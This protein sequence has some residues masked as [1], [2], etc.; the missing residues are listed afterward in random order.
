MSK[1]IEERKLPTGITEFDALI[2]DLMSEYGD[3]MPTQDVES[4][5]FVV[6]TIMMHLGQ[7]DSHKSLEFF[8]KRIVAGASKQIAHHI[9]VETKEKQMKRA[10]DEAA[11]AAAK[12]VP[13]ETQQ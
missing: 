6:A 4:I 3:E 8:Y 5:K 10:A 2:A 13:S 11:A 1:R 7:D 12:E 9:F